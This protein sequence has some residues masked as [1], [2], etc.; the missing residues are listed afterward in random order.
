MGLPQQMLS[1]CPACYKNFLNFY[2]EMTCGL[3]QSKY[4]WANMTS[5]Y[6][7][8]Y[9]YEPKGIPAITFLM[10]DSYATKFYNSCKDV[11]MPSANDKA[12]SMFCG[13]KAEDCTPLKWLSY[14]GN[15][16]N[17]R[18]PFMI[19]YRF[20]DTEWV[21]PD[22][23]TLIPL[24][25]TNTRCNETYDNTSSPCSCQ[26]CS[27][28]CAPFPPLPP[29]K[30]PFTILGLDGVSFIMACIFTAFVIVFGTYVICYNIVRENSFSIPADSDSIEKTSHTG[31]TK[32]LIQRQ[33][34]PADIWC[35]EKLGSYVENG[36][37]KGFT[38]WGRF[39]ANHPIIIVIASLVVGACFAGGIAMYDVTTDP[40]KLWSAPDSVA[41]TEK[42]YFDSHFG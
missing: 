41:R 42:H 27:L 20:Q 40:V 18:A 2:C 31:S 17:G 6:P 33:I 12:I 11:Q 19:Y 9:S 8:S 10:T 35:M 22:N 14:M 34:S 39:C 7:P 26:D 28:S 30:K 37:G 36:L 24:N 38:M 13:T 32:N 5:P 1:R 15:T 23:L 3:K 29:P 16:G 4:V 25:A 21:A